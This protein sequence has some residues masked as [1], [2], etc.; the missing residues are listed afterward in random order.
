MKYL[1][2]II[3][4]IIL[5]QSCVL[6]FLPNKQR[7]TINT[8]Q[9]DAVVY[10]DNEGI[11]K[12]ATMK[13]K[14]KKNGTKQVV[15]RTPSHK[16]TYK[17]LLPVRRSIAY[18]PLA[19]LDIP[20]STFFWILMQDG[21]N[22][23]F[24]AFNKQ[25]NFTI[26]DK[27]IKREVLD[28]YLI[29]N[30]KSNIKNIEIFPIKYS[31]SE[32]ETRIENAENNKSK[33]LNKE[34]SEEE[35]RRIVKYDDI[36]SASR[37][38]KT[39]KKTGFV[40]TVNVVFGDNNNTLKLE[41]NIKKINIYTINKKVYNYV[42]ARLFITWYIK[43]TYNE[44]LDSLESKDYSG[45]FAVDYSSSDINGII[46]IFQDMYADGLDISYL[47]I[48]KNEGFTKYLKQETD[49][50]IKDDVLSIIKPNNIVLEKTD[51]AQASVIVKRKD[52]GHGS[53][54]AISNDGYII[55]NFHVI[56]GKTTSNTE[57]LKIITSEGEELDVTVVRVNKYRDLALLKVTKIFE[58]AF[59][60]SSV[61]SF[62]NMQD[63][64]T[65]G[66]PKS[67]ELGQSISAGVISNERK[68]NNNNLL[69]LGMSINAGNSGGPLYDATGKLHGVIVSKLVGEN[70]EGVSFAIPG[71]LI[72]EYLN[73]KIN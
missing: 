69:Q 7:I 16:D 2:L 10:I 21:M 48:H 57:P 65:I 32:L 60:V 61:K 39:L 25:N 73:L 49:F 1:L 14:V 35:I 71:Y 62:R 31:E 45:D 29:V 56:A 33:P 63:A 17:V 13:T 70:T 37:I 43:N 55:T 3:M 6:F 67:V 64:H 44:V 11:G 4:S 12:G 40:D 18:W 5:L 59:V 23:E 30:V 22:S 47:H 72:E 15:I 66:A 27:L 53:G 28:K 68:V 58:K 38:N 8:G 34:M 9:N 26:S 24:M 20:L 42:K 41:A 52:G 36:K 54:F 51:A 46:K 19:A 50:T